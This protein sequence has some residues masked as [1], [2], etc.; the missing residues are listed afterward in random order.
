MNISQKNY[1]QRNKGITLIA[2]VVTIIVLI[3]LAAITINL[4]LGENGIIQKA[5]GA[6][7]KYSEEQA[8]EKLM[9]EIYNLQ[10]QNENSLDLSQLVQ[11]KDNDIYVET[12]DEQTVIIYE[13]DKK[14]AI[15][16][17][18]RY[19]FK[20]YEDLQIVLVGEKREDDKTSEDDKTLED[21]KLNVNELGYIDDGLIV[22][23]DGE[24]NT[25]NGHDATA[26]TWTN[27]AKNTLGKN[28]GTLMNVDFT[29]LSGW[30]EKSLILD[31]NNDWVKMS[32]LH[33]ENM[34]V[35]IVAKPL[36][37]NLSKNQIYISNCENG[38]TTIEK[39]AN[40]YNA[41]SEHIGGSYRFTN[42]E[43]NIR[44][45]QTYS[46]STGYNGENAYF[47]ENDV[48]YNTKITGK[49]TVPEDSTVFVIGT[50]PNGSKE[51]LTTNNARFNIEVYSVRIYNRCLTE[52]E[53]KHNYEIDKKRYNLDELPDTQNLGYIENGLICLY[54]GEQNTKYGHSKT[55]PTWMDLTGNNKDG[56]LMNVDFTNASGWT[57]KSLILDGSNDWV[58]MKY[59]YYSNMTIE[60]VAKPLSI[61]L[62]KAQAYLG[63]WQA[64]GIGI[65]KGAS[66]YI[67]VNAYIGGSYKNAT[68]NNTPKVGTVYSMSAG[69]NGA[70]L[71]YRENNNTYTTNVTGK[72]TAPSESTV[73]A[74]GTDPDGTTDGLQSSGT[75]SN[76]EVYSVRIYNRCLTEEEIQQNY[77]IDKQRFNI[78]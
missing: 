20:V 61:D 48:I 43:K 11:V 60:I 40:N 58:K 54:D 34:T 9:L 13:E 72:F 8:K 16:V 36:D 39:T 6:S 77:E 69:Y 29:E 75:R 14:Y 5:K 1:S 59:L 26:V 10:I 74:I 46:M 66:D 25:G 12:D 41:G 3:I 38:G 31:G 55:T 51:T 57:E 27:L 64:G 4:V 17:V 15:C 70:K 35:E 71:Y 76:I 21:D 44:I 63:N 68:S 19:K 42:S 49:Y 2:L 78:Q 52:N 18:D 30:T 37:I 45:A 73:F 24:N 47:R 23:Y 28:D 62:K 7:S 50:N 67:Y 22:L 56:T 53:I 33:Y 65:Q 32:Y